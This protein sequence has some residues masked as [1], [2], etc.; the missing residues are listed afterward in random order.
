MHEGGFAFKPL[1]VYTHACAFYTIE[2]RGIALPP[3]ICKYHHSRYR[4]LQ[5]PAKDK[6]YFRSKESYRGL[7]GRIPKRAWDALSCF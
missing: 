5:L 2:H 1:V 3:E 4:R 7:L 6:P